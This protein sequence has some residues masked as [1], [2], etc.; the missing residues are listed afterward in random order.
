MQSLFIGEVKNEYLGNNPKLYEIGR[1]E[2]NESKGIQ[3]FFPK[4][5]D[6][7]NRKSKYRNTK[8]KEYQR[9]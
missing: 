3:V 8:M 1:V 4:G 9:I 5:Q 6:K 2:D 7:N